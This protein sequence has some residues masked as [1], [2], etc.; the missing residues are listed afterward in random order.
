[1]AFLIYEW[2]STFL[3]KKKKKKSRDGCKDI[4]DGQVEQRM[5]LS[6]NSSNHVLLENVWKTIFYFFGDNVPFFWILSK[7]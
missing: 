2:Y 4:W 6:P 7:K 1:M 3:K 5:S